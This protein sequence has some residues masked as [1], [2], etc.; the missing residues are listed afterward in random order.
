MEADKRQQEAADRAVAAE[1]QRRQEVERRW[2]QEEQQRQRVAEAERKRQ[3]D[4]RLPDSLALLSQRTGITEA[5]TA[6]L[7]HAPLYTLYTEHHVTSTRKIKIN[8]GEGGGGGGGGGGCKAS[9]AS[10]KPPQGEPRVPEQL[11]GQG[12][13]PALADL[14]AR[15]SRSFWPLLRATR[16]PFDIC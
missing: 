13:L 14:L 6:T 2:R 7:R 4:A 9:G 10:E 15:P 11:L 12:V 3:E 5:Q 1:R 16:F 8:R